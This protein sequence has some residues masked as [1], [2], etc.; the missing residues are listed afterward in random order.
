MSLKLCLAAVVC[1][2]VS[3]CGTYGVYSGGAQV[4]KVDRR[5]EYLPAV[6]TVAQT[7]VGESLIHSSVELATTTYSVPGIKLLRAVSAT[8]S[9]VL[10]S[11][12]IDLPV[13]AV[14][15]LASNDPRG[16]FYVYNK[17]TRDFLP[18]LMFV[19]GSSSDVKTCYHKTP[20][21]PS[22][23]GYYGCSSYQALAKGVDFE[24]VD[25]SFE[26]QRTGEV[27]PRREL[28]FQ[29]GS[30]KEVRLL[31]REFT[32]HDLLKPAFTQSLTYDISHDR[33]IGFRSMR[34]EVVEASGTSMKYKVLRYWD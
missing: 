10:G 20:P 2:A 28:V 24:F 29:G 8:A 25:R 1:M 32:K 23:A 27:V 30:P 26:K 31:Y 7:E 3:G 18:A 11:N 19:G 5:N 34:V 22:S 4:T 13:G 14:L 33:V 16:N 6:G 9:D 21:T 15:E 12:E 17:V